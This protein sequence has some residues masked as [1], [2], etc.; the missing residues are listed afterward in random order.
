MFIFGLKYQFRSRL[1]FVFF[2]NADFE[3][4]YF[5]GGWF[6]QKTRNSKKQKTEV[7]KS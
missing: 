4:M 3:K 5:R 7:G 2:E 6:V 1:H